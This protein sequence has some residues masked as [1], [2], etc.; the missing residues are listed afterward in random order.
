MVGILDEPK[1]NE[2]MN[3]II[4]A[5]DTGQP[6]TLTHTYIDV[7]EIVD[8]FHG[9]YKPYILASMFLEDIQELEEHDLTDY[10][11]IVDELNNDLADSSKLNDYL[12]VHNLQIVVRE[13][14]EGT[15]CVMVKQGYH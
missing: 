8:G 11:Q 3:E 10:N 4:A 9:D 5:I 14:E 13:N 15:L 1:V 2:L 6:D 7:V 12:D